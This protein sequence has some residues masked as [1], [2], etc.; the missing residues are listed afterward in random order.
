MAAAN[1]HARETAWLNGCPVYQIDHTTRSGFVEDANVFHSFFRQHA[2]GWTLTAGHSVDAYLDREGRVQTRSYCFNLP[3]TAGVANAQNPMIHVHEH[4]N[5]I[6]L[7]VEKSVIAG[8]S[9]GTEIT[10]APL[11]ESLWPRANVFGV[12]SATSNATEV[13]GTFTLDTDGIL[14]LFGGPVGTVFVVAAG[15][16]WD[17][18]QIHYDRRPVEINIAV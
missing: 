17:R 12:I 6:F 1:P 16:G 3:T 4:G 18:F 13:I 10:F 9:A 7:D 2:S 11:P 14:H 5:Q 8:N 15:C